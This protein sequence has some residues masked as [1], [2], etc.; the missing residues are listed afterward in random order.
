MCC[1][2]GAHKIAARCGSQSPD[3][4]LEGGRHACHNPCSAY[5][6]PGMVHWRS[7][8]RV[9]LGDAGCARADP[10]ECP[11]QTRPSTSARSGLSCSGGGRGAS[12]TPRAA[13]PH[14]A[15]G[16]RTR[17]H[18]PT[19][20]PSTQML[21][22][23]RCLHLAA[24]S[25]LPAAT[26]HLRPLQCAAVPQPPPQ[27]RPATPRPSIGGRSPRGLSNPGSGAEPWASQ[28]TQHAA[29]AQQT[30]GRCRSRV[31]HSCVALGMRRRALRRAPAHTRGAHQAAPLRRWATLACALRRRLRGEGPP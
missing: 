31:V 21:E 13:Q 11:S 10:A 16:W 23:R 15:R 7:L 25:R 22:Q 14:T 8:Q 27:L 9:A 1:G 17:A 28:R 18:P 6:T 19:A 20:P 29:R 30:S 5:S 26:A 24:L 12:P 2:S 4:V 3:G